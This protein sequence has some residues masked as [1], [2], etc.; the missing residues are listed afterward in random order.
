MKLQ[1]CWPFSF[2]VKQH[3]SLRIHG[4]DGVKLLET[5]S[6]ADAWKD[7]RKQKIKYEKEKMVR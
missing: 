7:S 6:P 3:K 5:A 1:I 2:T 4:D